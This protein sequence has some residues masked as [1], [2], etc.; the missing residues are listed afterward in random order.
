MALSLLILK[1]IA[2]GFNNYFV[3]IGPRLSSSIPDTNVSPEHFLYNIPSPQNSLFFTPT[4]QVEVHKLCASLKS[5][6]SPGY[7]DIKSD[8]V[9][10]V[11]HL[12]ARPLA[13]IFNLSMLTGIVPIQFKIAK[14]VPIF[15]SG[16]SD[17]CS[18]YHPI[19]VA[20][21]VF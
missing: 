10:A 5:G 3:N 8:V 17:V 1:N 16:N 12:I 9:K 14:V 13:H 18:N 15:K 20:P 21:C 6:T 7:D 19:S 11:K 2:D 4:D